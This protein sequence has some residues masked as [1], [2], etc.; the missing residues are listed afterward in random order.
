MPRGMHRFDATRVAGWITALFALA[1]AAATLLPVPQ[2]DLGVSSA[3][4]I[5]HL[6]AFGALTLPMAMVRPRALLWLL[7]AAIA[8]GGAI[9]VIQPFVGR[10]REMGDFVADAAGACL[11]ASLGLVIG[12]W[13]RR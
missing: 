2:P 3:D 11:G 7:P 8:F 9:E 1:I 4:K 13:G 5:Q 10:S 12:R 6:V